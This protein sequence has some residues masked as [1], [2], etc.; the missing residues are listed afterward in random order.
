MELI[1]KTLFE[2]N[3]QIVDAGRYIVT[4][5]IEHVG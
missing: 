2:T 1:A 5:S 4:C 3:H